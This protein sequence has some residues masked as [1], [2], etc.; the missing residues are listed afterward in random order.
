MN[1]YNSLSTFPDVDAGLSI[2]ASLPSLD[3]YIFSNGTDA[4][5]QA[6]VFQSPSLSP[7]SSI[8]KSLVTVQAL[9]CYKPDPRVYI[10]LAKKVGKLSLIEPEEHL[11][12][13]LAQ[14][15]GKKSQF[16]SI[17][18]VSGNPFDVVGARAVGMNAAWVDRVGKGWTDRLI[19]PK[20]GGPTI[21]VRG[22][23]E[24]VREIGK[25]S[26]DRRLEN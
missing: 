1:A 20:T 19:D 2:L 13:K 8:F 5:V 9:G 11:A 6:S 21:V 17:W 15:S 16:E 26:Q 18:L 10:H 22:V 23:D 12:E 7:H 25:W 4:M 14:I 3:A 24:A